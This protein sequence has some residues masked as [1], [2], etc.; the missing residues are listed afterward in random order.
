M[1]TDVEY[2]PHQEFGT[3]Y[4]PGTPHVRPALETAADA[5]LAEIV[6]AAEAQLGAAL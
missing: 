4:Q 3:R 6:A 5:I 2:A 1:G